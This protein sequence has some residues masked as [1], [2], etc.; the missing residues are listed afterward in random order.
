MQEH[1]GPEREIATDR[2]ELTV[3]DVDHVEHAEDQAETH[4]EERVE[5]AQHHALDQKLEEGFK[6]RGQAASSPR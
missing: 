6:H 3:R 1:D 5:P 2:E 4:G